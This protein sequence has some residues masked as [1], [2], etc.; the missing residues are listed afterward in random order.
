MIKEDIGR[1]RRGVG[2]VGEYRK[3]S[4]REVKRRREKI[5]TKTSAGWEKGGNKKNYS[6]Q[7]KKTSK[8]RED[9]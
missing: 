9:D 8:E 7:G 5:K 6:L 4:R 2:E 1:Q 3:E